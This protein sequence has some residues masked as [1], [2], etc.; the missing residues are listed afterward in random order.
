GIIGAVPV[1]TTATDREGKFAV[2]DYARRHEL[3]VTDWSLAKKISADILNGGLIGFCVDNDCD[4]SETER[5]QWRADDR[6]V[7]GADALEQ[8]ITRGIQI[9]YFQSIKPVFQETLQLVPQLFVVGIGCRKGTSKEEIAKAVGQ[10]LLQENIHDKA[11]YALAS[12]DLK[13]QEEGI[14]SYCKEAGL[15]FLTYSSEELRSVEGDYSES[16][17]V[18]QITGV[19][20]VCERSAVLAAGGRLICK[21]RVYNGVTVAIARKECQGLKD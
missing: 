16:D 2:D 8:P 6:G 4:F 9:S 1:I 5:N 7:A 19:S 15:L 21:K 17:F 13:A 18:E 20:N 3:I 12:I 14:L 11:V 10:C